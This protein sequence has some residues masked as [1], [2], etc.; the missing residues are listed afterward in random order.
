MLAWH[1]AGLMPW[2]PLLAGCLTG[3]GVTAALR[4]FAGPIETPVDLGAGVRASFVPVVAGLAFLLHDPCRQLTGALPAGA[5]L[6]PATRI[7]LALPVLALSGLIQLQVAARALAADLNAAGQPAAGLP[8][9][10]L[11]AELAAWCTLAIALA[12]GL[13]RTRWRDLA[14][15]AAAALALAI[16]GVLALLPFHLL[17]AAI[18][19]MT[20]TQRHQWTAAWRLW[21]TVGATTT[22]IAGWAAGDPWRRV[23]WPRYLTTLRAW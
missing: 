21:I 22:V 5:W 18:I 23:R 15:L 7:G 19:A 6:T 9:L 14:G 20:N 8:W 4:I 11:T 3:I 13:D 1:V 10:A 12:A 17:P 16:V 2:G